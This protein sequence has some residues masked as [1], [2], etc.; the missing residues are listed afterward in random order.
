MMNIAVLVCSNDRSDF[1]A[2][3]PND[4]E[5]V[6]ALLSPLRPDW[7]FTIYAV[8]D[9]DFPAE[10]S[11]HDGFVITGSPASVH[12]GHDWI[13][14]LLALI[15]ELNERERPTVGLCFGHQAVAEALGG[16]VGNNRDGWVLGTART[17][18]TDKRDWMTPAADTVD[19][20]AAH[21]EQVTALPPGAQALGQADES[22]LAAFAI[23]RHIMTTG[24]HPEMTFD[25]IDG[26]I[27]EIEDTVGPRVAARAREQIKQ[28]PDGEVFARWM[29]NFFEGAMA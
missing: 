27:D 19:L 29:V 8:T 5:K 23:G 22:P 14:R 15:V 4:G 9:G 3:F 18:F 13:K 26:L 6:R 12:D 10:G 24:Y 1:S 21:R 20:Y 17:T 25:F 7:T 11:A 2:R 28:T 16:G